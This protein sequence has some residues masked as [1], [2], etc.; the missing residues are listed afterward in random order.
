L[1]KVF[2]KGWHRNS[3]IL[4]FLTTF[5]VVFCC[6]ANL[7]VMSAKAH[8]NLNV[9]IRIIHV[10]HEEDGL[11]MFIRLPMA[12]LVADKLGEEQSDGTLQPAPYTTNVS[13]NG[14]LV[15]YLDPTSLH[16]DPAG[17]AK[18]ILDGHLLKVG[19]IELNPEFKKL[20]AYPALKQVAFAT[21]EEAENAMKGPVYHEDFKATYVGDTVID[22]EVF[23]PTSEP[24]TAY[25]LQSTLDPKL[26]L[27]EETANL[28]LDHKNSDT[29]TFRLRG[30]LSEPVDISRSAFKAFGTFIMEGQRHI[31]IGVDH[32]LFVFCLVLGAVTFSSLL[33]RVT[34][35]TIGHSITL[36]AGFFGYVPQGAWFVPLVEMVIAL[37]IIYAAVI[38]ISQMQDNKG[39]LLITAAIGLLHGMGFSFVLSEILQIDSSNVWQSLLAFNVG[40]ELG[41]IGI[42]LATWPLLYL[43]SKRFPERIGNIRWV[44]AMPC[45][46]LASIW[47]GQRSLQLISSFS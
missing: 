6:I 31:L 38:A 29:L 8:F 17:L 37:S 9:N 32:V 39:S 22:A 2:D 28:I 46:V 36:S 21:L 20:R 12:Y 14:T 45:I 25:K 23:Y 30:L 42:V 41:Q 34:G 27:Q 33:W 35:F 18:I 44:L 19:S 4:F 26:P 40:V 5:L 7:F 43:L 15:H 16:N 13:E 11:R 24:V 10:S 1:H 3:A 47:T